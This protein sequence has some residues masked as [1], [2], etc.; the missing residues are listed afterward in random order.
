[1]PHRKITRFDSIEDILRFAMD[2]ELEAHQYYLD[3]AERTADPDMK[4]FLEKLAD[5]EQN[6]YAIL[7]EKLEECRA[8][9]FCMES[10]LASFNEEQPS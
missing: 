1:M 6:H 4:R 5:M 7:K 3:A 8:N 9:N 10:I 2:D